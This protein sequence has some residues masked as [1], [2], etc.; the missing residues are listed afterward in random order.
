VSAPHLRPSVVIMVETATIYGR[1]ILHGITRYL[2]SHEPWS[3]F[4]EQ[5]ELGVEPPPWLGRWKGQ[6]LITRVMT[7]E[8]A[9]WLRKS[10]LAVVDLNDRIGNAGLPRINSDDEAIGRLAAEHLLD[11]GFRSFGYCGFSNELWAERRRFGFMQ[12][13]T[14][15]G[16]T[17]AEFASPWVMSRT[18][19]WERQQE[20]INA[21]LTP[22]PRPLGLFACND[23]RGQH[24]L[25]AC[26]RLNWSVPE[27]AAVIGVDDDALLCEL[28]DPPLSSVIPS[29]ERIGYEAAELLDQQMRGQ[30][31][32]SADRYLPPVGVF[33]RQSTDVLAI[34]DPQTAAA[35]RFI[36]E[37][38]CAG[39]T[40]SDL[41]KAV[42]QS[43]TVLERKFRK[44]LGRSPQAEIRNVQIKRARQLLAETDLKLDRIAE[45]CGFEHPEYLS[46]VFKRETGDTPGQYRRSAHAAPKRS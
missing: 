2:R 20:Q 34:D 21:W 6:G 23:M 14:E 11:R 33:T 37:Q 39:A 32:E 17:S 24:V 1:R 5:H 30:P 15:A 3:V 25:D 43:R 31:V 18:E 16:F 7:P 35:V 27:E 28:C 8:F 19:S 13:L 10:K 41:L 38:A 40:V 46:V 36:R 42:P 29:A 4:L 12:R 22:L 9:V 26:T 44:Y 45:L